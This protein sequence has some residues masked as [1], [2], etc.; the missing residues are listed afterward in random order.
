MG[1]SFLSPAALVPG[2]ADPQ[3]TKNLGGVSVLRL[4]EIRLATLS[5]EKIAA[6]CQD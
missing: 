5:F 6:A 2:I 3:K 1:S 4:I